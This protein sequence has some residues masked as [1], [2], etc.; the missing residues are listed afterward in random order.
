[1]LKTCRKKPDIDPQSFEILLTFANG[2]GHKFSQTCRGYICAHLRRIPFKIGRFTNIK[3]LYQVVSVDFPFTWSRSTGRGRVSTLSVPGFHMHGHCNKKNI[4]L[5]RERWS[6]KTVH[7]TI[8]KG[9]IMGYDQRTFPETVAV[10]STF[11]A[12]L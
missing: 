5:F 8:P 6:E 4:Q 3:A 11:V 10:E 2:E 1:M 12:F 7:V 9:N